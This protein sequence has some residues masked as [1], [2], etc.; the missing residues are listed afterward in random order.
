MIPDRLALERRR[1][2]RQ[3]QVTPPEAA[4]AAPRPE[5]F[6][7][8]RGLAADLG[9]ELELPG[10]P[11]VVV[12]L[13]RALG[14]QN[15][16]AREVV[17]LVTAE[18]ALSGRLL[19]LANS[20]AFNPGSRSVADL[21]SA[22]TLLGFNVVRSTATSFAMRQLQQ[23]EWLAPLRPHLA[24]LW[25]ESTTVAAICFSVARRVPTL[26]PDEALAVGLFHQI[27]SLYV[28]TRAH[29]EG[30][31]IGEVDAWADT[32]SGWHPSIARILLEDWRLPG[33]L[34]AAVEQQDAL[35]DARQLSLLPRLL[36]A[37]KAWRL[38]QARGDEASPA[39]VQRLEVVSLGEASFQSLVSEM[40]D[41]I[42]AMSR[43][44]S[45]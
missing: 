7:F 41:E 35:D 30:V 14:D 37:S 28:L 36:A 32:I 19:K 29:R 27:G 8:V 25:K 43:L 6:N 9:G 23:Q 4:P 21:K 22:I 3:Q 1:T 13:H 31:V 17:R 11:D 5:L 10:F 16:S 42:A 38:A 33:H 44:I 18:P 24:A 40:S 45:G 15:S 26:R 20:A 2:D 34:A 12:N 39:L